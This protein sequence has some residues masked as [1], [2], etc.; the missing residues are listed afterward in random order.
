M[1]FAFPS[2]PPSSSY[3][4]YVNTAKY[5]EH[6]QWIAWRRATCSMKWRRTVSVYVLEIAFIVFVS[7]SSCV[8]CLRGIS[9]HL[10]D[11][12]QNMFCRQARVRRVRACIWP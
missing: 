2:S 10:I 12:S 8:L 7:Q 3:S 11:V 6:A 1:A 5:N 9:F 4:I